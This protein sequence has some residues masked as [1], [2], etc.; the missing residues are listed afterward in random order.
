MSIN[1]TPS[2]N[3]SLDYLLGEFSTITDALDYAAQGETGYNFYNLRGEVVASLPYSELRT[4]ALDVADRLA[5]RFERDARIGL[6]ADTSAEF[7]VTFFAC[8]YAGLVPAP[9]PLPV[10][11]GGKDG[12]ILQLTQMLTCAD[13]AAAI[14]P[15]GL[16]DFLREAANACENVDVIDFDALAQL[17]ATG[18]PRAFS[19]DEM[20]YI[21]LLYTSPSPRDS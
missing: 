5:G 3:S 12:Y 8:Q 1:P 14:G 6:V 2:R 18:D 17:P 10:N 11:L 9:M 21:C 19:K 4:R 7:F 16:S 20:C 15:A 13:A